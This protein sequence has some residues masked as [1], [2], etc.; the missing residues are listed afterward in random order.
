MCKND[1]SVLLLFKIIM[2]N[3]VSEI[4]SAMNQA[5][6]LDESDEEFGSDRSVLTYCEVSLIS[7]FMSIF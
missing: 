5:E 1:D 6:T 2:S 4:K 7:Y 3:D